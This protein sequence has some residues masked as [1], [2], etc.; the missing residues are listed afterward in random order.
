MSGLTPGDGID[1]RG[2]PFT[3]QLF[4]DLLNALREGSTS[5]G[6]ATFAWPVGWAYPPPAGPSMPPRSW[7]RL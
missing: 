4:H 3:A 6:T 7:P 5:Q 1:H 2:T